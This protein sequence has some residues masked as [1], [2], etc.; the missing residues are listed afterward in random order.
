MLAATPY[1]EHKQ[2]MLLEQIFYF[3]WTLPARSSACSLR[4]TTQVCSTG[5]NGNIGI[6]KHLYDGIILV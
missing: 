4:L 5:K 6:W 2:E 1:K 3:I